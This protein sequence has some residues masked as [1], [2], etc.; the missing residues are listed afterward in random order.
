MLLAGGAAKKE[1][2]P[3]KETAVMALWSLR[4]HYPDQVK[5]SGLQLKP[6]SARLH[7]APAFQGE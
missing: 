2:A 5:R 4:R 3:G 7:R 1:A 6:L